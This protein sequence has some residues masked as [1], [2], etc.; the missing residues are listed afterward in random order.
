[1]I[2]PGLKGVRSIRIDASDWAFA[3]SD[4]MKPIAAP[5]IGGM[6]TSSIRVQPAV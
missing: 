1:M 2:R 3:A 4:I 5:I 6:V